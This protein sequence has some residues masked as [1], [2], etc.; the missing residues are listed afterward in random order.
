MKRKCA[1]FT[2]VKNE[3][4]FL[5]IWLKHYK[6]FF[7]N[8]DIFVLDHQS[9]DG[10][11]EDLDVNVV[12]VNN[13][14][15]FDHQWLVEVVQAFQRRLLQDYDCVLFA[16]SDEILYST[17]HNLDEMISKFMAEDNDYIICTGFEITQN[18]GNEPELKK[19]SSIIENRNFWYANSQY[20]KPLLTKVPLQ[21]AWGFHNLAH[22]PEHGGR[23][24]KYGFTMAH[25]HRVDFELMMER[26]EERVKNWNLKD[27]GYAGWHHKVAERQELMDYFNLPFKEG[28]QLVEIP[29]T[30]KV[31][32]SI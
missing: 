23:L 8:Q 29:S 19:D 10:S 9:N 11:T 21:Y 2:I 31:R 16:E 6:R 1:V 26:H 28:C 24:G 32:L 12:P 20:N 30:H 7:D 15:A 3:K 17:E 13:D 5:P 25:L 18:I 22:Y 14:V 27:D 4:Y